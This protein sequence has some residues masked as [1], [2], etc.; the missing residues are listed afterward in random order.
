[1]TLVQLVQV[2]PLPKHFSVEDTFIAAVALLN[3]S[4]QLCQDYSAKVYSSHPLSAS[5]VFSLGI[6]LI[7]VVFI[8]EESSEV[9]DSDTSD[10]S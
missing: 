5:D 2:S 9:K 10:L 3:R 7:K 4:T 8:T 1:M 6:W